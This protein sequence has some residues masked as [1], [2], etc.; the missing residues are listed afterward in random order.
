MEEPPQW[1]TGHCAGDKSTLTVLFDARLWAGSC[2]HENWCLWKQWGRKIPCASVRRSLEPP[3]YF[4][5]GNWISSGMVRPCVFLLTSR[6]NSIQARHPQVKQ[7]DP[8]GSRSLKQWALWGLQ[9]KIKA[10]LRMR[11]WVLRSLML[12][13]FLMPW[14]Q[15]NKFPGNPHLSCCKTN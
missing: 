5:T 10:N 14:Q 12:S 15:D 2:L 4:C 3:E 11:L 13:L 7:A 6:E 8:W 1:E 9:W